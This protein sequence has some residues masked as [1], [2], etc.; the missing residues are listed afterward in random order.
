MLP[1][2]PIQAD[3]AD[4]PEILASRNLSSV[5]GILL[6]GLML[7]CARSLKEVILSLGSNGYV[8]FI[9]SFVIM[10][11]IGLMTIANFGTL[12]RE[13]PML[14]PLFLMLFALAPRPKIKGPDP[15]ERVA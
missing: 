9:L 5:D 10:L 15:Q 13:R 11:S 8:V 2:E 12:A 6:M 1:I 7:W 14:L 4:L 3:Y